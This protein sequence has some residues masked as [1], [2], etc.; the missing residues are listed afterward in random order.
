VKLFHCL[1]SIKALVLTAKSMQLSVAYIWDQ[2]GAFRLWH[3]LGSSKHVTSLGNRVFCTHLC[4]FT[5]SRHV[6]SVVLKWCNFWRSWDLCA[7]H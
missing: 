2:H 3:K 6:V 5:F 4:I 1:F 7:V